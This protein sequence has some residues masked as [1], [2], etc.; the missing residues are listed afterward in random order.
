MYV[1]QSKTVQLDSCDNQSKQSPINPVLNSEDVNPG[2]GI[3]IIISR[4]KQL[5]RFA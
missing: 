4:R 5:P 2:A 1:A 3:V